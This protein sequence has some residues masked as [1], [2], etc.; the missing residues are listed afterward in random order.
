MTWTVLVVED[1]EMVREVMD[2]TLTQ[3]GFRVLTAGSG[4]AGLDLMRRLQI[5]LVLLDVHMPRM[6][7]LDVLLSMKRMGRPAP[8]VMMVSANRSIETVQGAMRLGCAGY[9]AKPFTPES[10]LGRVRK[11]L[12][13]RAP[14]VDDAVEI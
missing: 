5:D 1:D 11:V 9:V 6:S 2:I 10:L 7:G 14:A 4:E 3:S 8:P 12:A 13:G